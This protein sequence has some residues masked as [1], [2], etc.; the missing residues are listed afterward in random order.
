MASPFDEID[1]AGQ[2]VIAAH[3]GE[4]VTFTGMIGGDYSN[5]PDPYRPPLTVTAVVALSPRT[6]AMAEGIQGRSSA[7]SA[8]V[9][10]SSELWISAADFAAMAWRPK[11]NDRA[12]VR[13]GEAGERE[14]TV[15]AVLPMDHDDVQVILSEVGRGG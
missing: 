4:A 7:G 6:G 13:P 3:L 8:R 14:F 10:T 15:S 1:A 11:T 2:A 12:T 5:A 9:H